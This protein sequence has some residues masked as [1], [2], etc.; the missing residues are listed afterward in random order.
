MVQGSPR[1]HCTQVLWQGC[2][3]KST[4]RSC[5]PVPVVGEEGK[6]ADT[7]STFWELQQQ[8]PTT[9]SKEEKTSEQSQK[10]HK[11][12]WRKK[13]KIPRSS[14]GLWWGKCGDKHWAP[15]GIPVNP[16][17]GVPTLLFF[18]S[19]EK[20]C[21]GRNWGAGEPKPPRSNIWTEGLQK[22]KTI[23]DRSLQ[24]EWGHVTYGGWF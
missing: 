22:R 9:D 20:T 7:F 12:S 17:L 16:A 23:C 10:T 11:V 14:E 19:C 5:P 8:R 21:H 24:E 1:Q 13:K 18:S 4:A 6:H 3:I 15:S 2:A